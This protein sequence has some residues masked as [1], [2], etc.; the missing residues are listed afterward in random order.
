MGGAFDFQ[1]DY[2]YWALDAI[3]DHPFGTGSATAQVNLVRWDGGTF[4]AALP[5]QTALMAE[6]GYRFADFWLSPILRFE[7]RWMTTPTAEAPDETRYGGGLA[8]WPFGHDTNLKAFYTRIQPDP[9]VHDYSQFVVQW[10]MYF[11]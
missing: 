4:I 10:Q 1:D 7:R 6:G 5:K 3:F 8:F 11:Y 9:G 2:R